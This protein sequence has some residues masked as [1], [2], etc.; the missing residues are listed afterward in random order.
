VHLTA[1]L[2]HEGQMLARPVYYECWS[3][4]EMGKGRRA[5]E[6]MVQMW[7]LRCGSSVMGRRGLLFT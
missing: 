4:G 3:C 7:I 5:I 1:R 2:I 6:K